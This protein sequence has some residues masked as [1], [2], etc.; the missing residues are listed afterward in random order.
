MPHL[1]D[2]TTDNVRKTIDSCI[3]EGENTDHLI[4]NVDPEYMWRVP[5]HHTK[6]GTI[7]SRIPQAE[8]GKHK[9]LAF[10]SLADYYLTGE[11]KT[12]FIEELKR[13]AKEEE[14]T[15]TEEKFRNV[16][17]YI[18]AE[19]VIMPNHQSSVIVWDTGTA[20][21]T[22][23]P[24]EGDLMDTLSDF[25]PFFN[26]KYKK[27]IEIPD[28]LEYQKEGFQKDVI[29]TISGVDSEVV[30]YISQLLDEGTTAASDYWKYG[31]YLKKMFRF[32]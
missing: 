17:V 6:A 19:F 7:L 8:N 15:F 11:R 27:T 20:V 10:A 29:V 24:T 30:D 5:T 16:V 32:L 21:L 31:E 23:D 4:L 13:I 22:E 28:Y 3:R 25:V 12:S 18:S 1:F 14:K 26:Y 9:F 2:I